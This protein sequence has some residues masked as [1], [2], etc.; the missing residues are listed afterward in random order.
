MP[1]ADLITFEEFESMD[2]VAQRDYVNQTVLNL[3]EEYKELI[4]LKAAL[5]SC[6][7]P[8]EDH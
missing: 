1:R 8:T 3:V 6:L 2:R 5:E 7:I 4:E